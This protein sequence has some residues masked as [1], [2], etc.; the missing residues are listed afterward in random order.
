MDAVLAKK[1][2]AMA[3]DLGYSER[4]FYLRY[5]VNEAN[6]ETMELIYRLW[7]KTRKE[8]KK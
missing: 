8:N 1:C 5:V 7:K 2:Q 3:R 4:D 6:Q